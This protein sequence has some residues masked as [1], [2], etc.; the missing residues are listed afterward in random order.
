M[1]GCGT[2]VKAELSFHIF[3]PSI[4]FLFPL[5]FIFPDMLNEDD[6]FCLIILVQE[7]NEDI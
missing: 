2:V 3:F 6:K 7:L 1:V 4:Q 5:T